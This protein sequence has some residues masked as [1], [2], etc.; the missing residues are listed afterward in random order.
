MLVLG[1]DSRIWL[2]LSKDTSLSK[3][4]RARAAY[5]HSFLTDKMV[6]LPFKLKA[7]TGLYHGN[8]ND[9]GDGLARLYGLKNGVDMSRFNQYKMTGRF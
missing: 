8:R 1:R 2:E 7:G 5:L 6:R 4:A 9:N 3:A